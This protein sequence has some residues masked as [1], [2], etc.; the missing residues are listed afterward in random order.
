[1]LLSS[2]PLLLSLPLL[3]AAAAPAPE[4]AIRAA[5]EQWRDDFN[6]GRADAACGLFAPDLIA[7][8]QG[9]PTRDF[10]SLCDLLHRSLADPARRYHYELD[11]QEILVSG[12]QA[13]VRLIWI[14]DLTPTGQPPERSRDQG[15]DIFRRQPD[16][17]WRIV[18]F[19][20]YPI[21]EPR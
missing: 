18:R 14:L 10:Q 20:G 6:A 8:F 4:G 21:I 1:V 16:G 3:A 15:L 17:A 11:L 12:E 5:L 7:D 19:I 9:G 2:L 13:A